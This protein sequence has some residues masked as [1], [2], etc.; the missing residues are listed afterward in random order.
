[1][2]DDK[3]LPFGVS[4]RCCKRVTVAFDVGTI[5]FDGDVLLLVGADKR[6]GLIDRLA[7]TI[8]VH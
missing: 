4:S 8:S 3:L 5:I 1:M 2:I 6:V 7:A